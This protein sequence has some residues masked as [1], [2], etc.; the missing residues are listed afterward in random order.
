MEIQARV[1]AVRSFGPEAHTQ[2][3]EVGRSAQEAHNDARQICPDHSQL[4]QDHPP[5]LWS[6]SLSRCLLQCGRHRSMPAPRL[7][8]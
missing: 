1:L 6:T 8:D 2:L 7:L 4:V 5:R 3:H